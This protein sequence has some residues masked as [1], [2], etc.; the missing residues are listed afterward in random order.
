M[1]SRRFLPVLLAVASAWALTVA[2]ATADQ[3]VIVKTRKPYDAV[4]E[5]VIAEQSAA[6]ARKEGEARLAAVR[7][8]PTEPLGET[9][10]VSRMQARVLPPALLDAAMRADASQLPQVRGVDLG[11]AGYAV[12]RVNKVLPRELPPGMTPGGPDPLRDQYAQAF[13]MAETEAYLGSL[14][15]RYKVEVKPAAKAAAAAT[16]ASSA[17]L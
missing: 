5:R 17:G 8:A 13:A 11:G 4:R 12:L 3:R 1:R 16:A 6:L 14:K 10:T 7:A 9:L 2:P 15:K